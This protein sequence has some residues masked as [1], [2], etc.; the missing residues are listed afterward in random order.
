M[1]SRTGP[2]LRV[3]IPS[4][5][6]NGTDELLRHMDVVEKE[7]TRKNGNIKFPQSK[8]LRDYLLMEDEITKFIPCVRESLLDP[9]RLV[10]ADID[11]SIKQLMDGFGIFGGGEQAYALLFGGTPTELMM[12]QEEKDNRTSLAAK[13]RGLEDILDTLYELIAM[14][15]HDCYAC[16]EQASVCRSELDFITDVEYASEN[17]PTS[18][19]QALLRCQ[20]FRQSLTMYVNL[21]AKH[22][23]HLEGDL[24]RS[25]HERA[26]ALTAAS[27]S[28]VQVGKK[29][30]RESKSR[31]VNQS[32][33]SDLDKNL[34]AECDL[35]E[36]WRRT[37]RRV[38]G[39]FRCEYMGK[40]CDMSEDECS[41]REAQSS[42][43]GEE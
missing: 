22:L 23:G 40:T 25:A 13:P 19:L 16:Y 14:L 6:T 33:E 9:L 4:D 28:E 43:Y 17:D 5:V 39:A 20:K 36:K 1:P 24:R 11:T 30:K 42:R 32:A 3:M 27:D 34:W 21:L 31:T 15:D 37:N 12:P 26:A 29:R 2:S 18:M 41:E 38:K 10:V 35:C 8:S 7:N